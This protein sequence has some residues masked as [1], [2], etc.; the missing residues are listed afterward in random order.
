ME[1]SRLQNNILYT[2]HNVSEG[3]EARRSERE[4]E[5]RLKWEAKEQKENRG[6]TWYRWLMR[7]LHASS[8]PLQRESQRWL[9]SPTS[10]GD[11]WGWGLKI[12]WVIISLCGCRILCFLETVWP[13]T[14]SLCSSF[15]IVVIQYPM[16]PFIC[17]IA[18]QGLQ[19]HCSAKKCNTINANSTVIWQQ[20]KHNFLFITLLL[21]RHHPWW[22]ITSHVFSSVAI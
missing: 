19:A 10:W 4:I 21:P 3:E 8:V 12:W 1:P 15:K 9:R 18:H 6:D 16:P 5:K 17:S 11:L 13:P 2:I 22:C 20:Q 7:W 14:S